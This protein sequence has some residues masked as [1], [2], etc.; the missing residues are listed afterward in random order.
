[1]NDIF[2][3]TVPAFT[4][5]NDIELRITTSAV[6]SGGWIP[7]GETPEEAE[8]LWRQSHGKDFEEKTEDLEPLKRAERSVA[9]KADRVKSKSQK[10]AL[11]EAADAIA[12]ATERAQDALTKAEA[13][14]LTNIMNAAVSA[15]NIKESIAQAHMATAMAQAMLARAEQDDEEQAIMLLLTQ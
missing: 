6:T 9:A 13:T 7:S 3:Y 14:R 12:E 11:R 1:M 4:D 5:P 10:Q 8:R 15:K 2:L